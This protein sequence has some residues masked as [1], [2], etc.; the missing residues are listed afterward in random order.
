MPSRGYEEHNDEGRPSTGRQTSNNSLPL[1]DP[2]AERRKI[3]ETYAAQYRQDSQN[4]TP[5]MGY[6]PLSEQPGQR[7]ASAKPGL[8]IWGT[9]VQPLESNRGSLSSFCSV[10]LL[11]SFTCNYLYIY[12]AM[13]FI[14]RLLFKINISQRRPKPTGLVHKGSVHGRHLHHAEL[15]A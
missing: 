3:H 9:S 5:P 11:A 12:P 15:T 8:L 14:H 1:I 4:G 10:C 2:I 7:C 6:V 13:L